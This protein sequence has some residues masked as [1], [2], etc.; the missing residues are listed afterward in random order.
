[1]DSL[2]TTLALWIYVLCNF[3]TIVIVLRKMRLS[4][5]I[6]GCVL[7]RLVVEAAQDVVSATHPEMIFELSGFAVLMMS[8]MIWKGKV[9]N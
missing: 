6:G 1:M 7:F 8:K 3:V 9:K 2:T 5:G 4:L